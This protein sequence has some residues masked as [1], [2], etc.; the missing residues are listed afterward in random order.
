MPVAVRAYTQPNTNPRTV[1]ARNVVTGSLPV[2]ERLAA[3]EALGGAVPAAPGPVVPVPDD[4][5]RRRLLRR[6][7]TARQQAGGVDGVDAAQCRQQRAAGR[8]GP[9]L[10][11]RLDEQLRLGPPE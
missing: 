6:R 3:V 5:A 11:Q 7:V 1:S 8:L 10:L 2:D 9:G 4:E